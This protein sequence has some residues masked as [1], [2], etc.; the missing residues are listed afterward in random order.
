MKVV[1]VRAC[2]LLLCG[3]HN[4]YIVCS[5]EVHDDN[6][7]HLYIVMCTHDNC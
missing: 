1:C 4:A 7:N 3:Q 2:Y 6:L 5:K